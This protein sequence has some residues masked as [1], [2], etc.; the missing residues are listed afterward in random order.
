MY[1]IFFIHFSGEAYLGFLQFLAITNKAAMN[2][3]AQVSLWYS[4]TTFGYMPKSG[5]V[6]LR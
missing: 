3:V 5:I 6:V 4:G 1:H 2:I